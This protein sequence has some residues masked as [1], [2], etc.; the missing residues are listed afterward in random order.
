M[1]EY[2]LCT[3][4][5]CT[6]T[7]MMFLF[8]KALIKK[9]KSDPESFVLGY[10]TYSVLVGI[11]GIIVQFFDLNWSI[12][13]KYMLVIWLL[14]LCVIIYQLKKRKMSFTLYS[15]KEYIQKNWVVFFVC[16][17]LGAMLFL[18]YNAYWYG[19]HLDDGYYI[20]KVATMPY[21]E[22]G[23]RTNYS[24]GVEKLGIDSYVFNTW[25]IEA[26]VY[27]KWLKVSATL[28][29]RLFQS[30]FHYFLFANCVLIFAKKI[31]TCLNDEYREIEYQFQTVIIIFFGAYYLYLQDTNLFFLRDAWQYN[32][33]MFLGSSIVRMI[34]IL[35]LLFPFIGKRNIDIKMILSVGGI[36]FFLMTKS[37]TALPIIV[38]VSMSYLIS[39]F[40]LE[41]K[42]IVG[43]SVCAI[44]FLV[45]FILP[46]KE[47]LEFEVY[48]YVKLALHSPIF[49]LCTIIFVIS[50]TFRKRI[51][52]QLNGI[53][54]L[55]I[56][57]MV[58]PQVN[59]V[60]ELFSVY[61]FVAGRTWTVFGYTYIV[62]NF[63]YGY[64]LLK[65]HIKNIN[66]MQ[67][68]YGILGIVFSIFIVCTF[69]WYGGELFLIEEGPVEANLR[70]NLEIIKD[71]INFVPKSTELLGSMLEEINEKS[72]DKIYLVCPELRGL[73]GT[74][75][76]LATQIRIFAPDIIS[77]SAIGR[78]PVEE[79]CV[80][81]GYNQNIFEDFLENPNEITCNRL[82]K[83]M[84]KYNIN[85]VVTTNDACSEYMEQMGFLYYGDIQECVYYVWY[86]VDI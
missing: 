37:S 83:E 70:G 18:Y 28:Y 86:R 23:F 25:E 30:I 47:K 52:Y 38:L 19:N 34:G 8:G 39:W 29:L 56:A 72:E 80:L 5:W 24:V 76:S 21:N 79:D 82:K 32:S 9:E 74:A 31:F 61:G 67:G 71:N 48:K 46:N 27:I 65:K 60:F 50:F 54:L 59:D 22:T 44:W 49:I 55:L 41:K 10:I 15:F 16:I 69:N 3:T 64:I 1:K 40:F 62:L 26:S 85:C 73:D 53:I 17:V 20:T 36:A 4:F 33:G 7:F 58:I 6:F 75:H 57:M 12:Y 84:D 66:I 45:A 51:V 77:V 11:G 13:E 78:Y 43:G 14:I 63:M 35:M 2:I 81:Y 68:V 42:Y